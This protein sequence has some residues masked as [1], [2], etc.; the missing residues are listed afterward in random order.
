VKGRELGKEWHL[1][2]YW[3]EALRA[4]RKNRKRQLQEIGGWG[5][6]TKRTRSLGG[7]ILLGLKERDLR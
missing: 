7:E 5:N 6:P 3:A 4:S 1:I 2:C